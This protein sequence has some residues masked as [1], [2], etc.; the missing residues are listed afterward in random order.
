[1]NEKVPLIEVT[2][3]MSRSNNITFSVRSLRQ[4]QGSIRLHVRLHERKTD[5]LNRK[6]KS[7]RR[8]HSFQNKQLIR[9]PPECRRCRRSIMN[10]EIFTTRGDN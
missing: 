8:I 1:M 3:I 9:L 4:R 5:I 6:R 7:E 10:S 2:T